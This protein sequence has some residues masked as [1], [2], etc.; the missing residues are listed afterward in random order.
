[1]SFCSSICQTMSFLCSEPTEAFHPIQ[2]GEWHSLHSNLSGPVLSSLMVLSL[3]P[4]PTALLLTLSAPTTQVSIPF[5]E[6]PRLVS[7][8]IIMC[9]MLNYLLASFLFSEWFLLLVIGWSTV[10][11]SSLCDL[12]TPSTNSIVKTHLFFK[13]YP[14]CLTNFLSC[15][16]FS[17]FIL[18]LLPCA[19]P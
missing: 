11:T 1:M 8:Q 3:T 18:L 12:K 14:W 17:A 15:G 16:P 6:L 4:S 7:F 10:K 2:S 13:I 5:L 9:H 19:T